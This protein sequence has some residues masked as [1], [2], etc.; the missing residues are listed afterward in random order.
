M[1]GA[2]GRRRG[3]CDPSL[4]LPGSNS[5]LTHLKLVF[6]SAKLGPLWPYFIVLLWKLHKVIHLK[7]KILDGYHSLRVIVIILLWGWD[8]HRYVGL[9][10]LG[11]DLEG[12]RNA[13]VLALQPSP[14][15]CLFSHTRAADIVLFSPVF[16]CYSCFAYMIDCFS[17]HMWPILLL[18]FFLEIHTLF[19][20][21]PF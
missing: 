9:W 4:L 7:N 15:I 18:N 8:A 6:P 21:V 5:N 16:L 3:R 11:G 17:N 12:F 20:T 13:Q 14:S 2:E 19:E 1:R 10:K